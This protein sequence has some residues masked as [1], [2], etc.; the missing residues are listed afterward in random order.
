MGTPESAALLLKA[1]EFRRRA[2]LLRVRSRTLVSE[3]T[4]ADLLAVAKTYDELAEDAE[5][6][7]GR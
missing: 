1:T 6:M 7:A 2:G 5:K 3:I 4:R